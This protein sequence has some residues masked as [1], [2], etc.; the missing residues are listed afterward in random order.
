MRVVIVG[1]AGRTGR[2]V[3]AACLGSGNEVAATVDRAFDGDEN[4]NC[5]KSICDFKGQADVIVDFSAPSAIEG[6]AAF[7]LKTNTPLVVATTGHNAEQKKLI[8]SVSKRVPV[9]YSAKLSLGAGVLV[10]CA[11]RALKVF[12]DAQ[13]E[14]VETHHAQKADSPSGTAYMIAT[15]LSGKK[16]VYA[17]KGKRDDRIGV[18]SVRYGNVVGIHTIIIHQG[19]Q[20]LTFT[21]QAD[22][23]SVFADGAIAAAKF[24]QGKRS[25]IYDVFDLISET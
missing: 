11:K 3:A 25:G 8:K 1:A 7:A 20:T 19:G 6:V 24:I 9:F 21:H 12:P 17:R 10:D 23:R 5:Y 18:S 4:K 16:P 13:I 14:I 15:K 2:E 22:D